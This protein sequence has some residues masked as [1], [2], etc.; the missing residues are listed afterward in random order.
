LNFA[1]VG[2]FGVFVAAIVDVVLLLSRLLALAGLSCFF[3]LIISFCEIFGLCAAGFS[4]FTAGFHPFNVSRGADIALWIYHANCW[5]QLRF[6][7]RGVS[8]TSMPAVGDFI[9]RCFA[10]FLAR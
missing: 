9:F 7:K 2:N 3:I 4:F 10:V 1:T 8:L 6:L 5:C